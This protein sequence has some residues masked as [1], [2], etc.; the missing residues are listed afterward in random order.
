MPAI[1]ITPKE[2]KEK[3]AQGKCI[4]LDLRQTDSYDGSQ[5]Q[6]QGSVRLDPND[7]A[8]IQRMIDNTDKNAAIVGYCT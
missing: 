1:R 3:M 2:L 4:I 6:I 8:A 5:E 7:D